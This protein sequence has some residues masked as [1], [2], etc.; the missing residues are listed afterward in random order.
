MEE[1][2][3]NYFIVAENIKCGKIQFHPSV[4]DHK[5]ISLEINRCWGSTLKLYKNYK[6]KTSQ[7]N[8]N[9]LVNELQKFRKIHI[10]SPSKTQN[11][12]STKM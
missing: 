10:K 8:Y 12:Q 9:K 7:N 3:I 2:K 4:S 11:A 5:F 1:I 6:P